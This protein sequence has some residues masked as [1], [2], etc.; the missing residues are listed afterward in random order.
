MV[1]IAHLLGMT[2]I[3]AIIHGELPI[4]EN[5]RQLEHM[6]FMDI[7]LFSEFIHLTFLMLNFC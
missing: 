7:L 1:I 5:A 2:W 3:I 4:M 6:C